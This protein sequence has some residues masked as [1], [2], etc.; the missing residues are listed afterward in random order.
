MCYCFVLWYFLLLSE[1]AIL[2]HL[3]LPHNTQRQIMHAHPD[4][5]KSEAVSLM[6]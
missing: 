1:S 4:K 2:T 6:S 3:I 5:N